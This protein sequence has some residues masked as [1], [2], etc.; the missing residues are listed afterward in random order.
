[1][2]DVA[3][4]SDADARRAAAQALAPLRVRGGIRA[5]FHAARAASHITDLGESGGYRLR[6]PTTHAPHI[7]AVQINT[8]GGVAGGDR[9]AFSFAADAGADVVVATQAAERI[10]RTNGPAA[11]IDV[12]L[13]LATAARLDWLPQETILFSGAR[14]KRRFDVD[15]AA[16]ARLLMLEAVTFG[17]IA[18]GEVMA[19]G[20][21]NDS[22]RVRRDGRLI[23]ADATRL[24]GPIAEVLAR[25]AVA[26]GDRAIALL[27]YVAPDAAD[28]L[29]S[30]RAVLA[31]A[32]SH[33]GAS[34]WNGMLTVRFQGADGGSVRRDV[35]DVVQ[36]LSRRPLPRVWQA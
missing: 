26:G 21:L 11:E 31:D 14:L 4:Q 8:G 27:L 20:G 35:I 3:S 28:R 2:S 19:D 30:V 33:C 6:F 34:T 1:M 29:D 22:W 15:L 24:D 16:D 32:R 5:R 12:R 36:T 10:Y 7:E 18:S 17:R 25:L 23:F 13:S 9:L